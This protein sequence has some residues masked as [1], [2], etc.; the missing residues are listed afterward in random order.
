MWI[1]NEADPQKGTLRTLRCGAA[2]EASLRYSAVQRRTYVTSSTE[3]F[4]CGRA[5]D[6]GQ[7]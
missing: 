7:L 4:R 5:P 6:G 1:A 2:G 3:T